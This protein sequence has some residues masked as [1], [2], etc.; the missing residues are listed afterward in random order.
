MGDNQHEDGM[1]A[2]IARFDRAM[3]RLEASVRSLNGRMRTLNRIEVDTQRLINERARLA[4]DLDKASAR[5]KRL[6]DSAHEVS[7][8]LVDAMETVRHVLAK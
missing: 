7:R 1:D 4:A 6:D 5:A 8:R 3:G 2:A